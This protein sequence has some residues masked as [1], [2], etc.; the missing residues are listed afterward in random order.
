LRRQTL[1]IIRIILEKPLHLSLTGFIDEAIPQLS[2]RMTEPKETVRRGVMDF[3]QGRLHHFLVS[4]YGFGSDIVDA[5]LAVG[6]EDLV[7]AVSRT[8]ALAAFKARPDFESLAI[9]FK[10]VFNIIKEPET[11]AV[12][13]EELRSPAEQ[14]L[15]SALL[16]A[17][18][19]VQG[20]L[21]RSDYDA[22]LEAMA[23]MKGP[24]DAFFDSVLVMDKDESVRRNRLALLT[25]IHDLF[26]RVADFRKIQTA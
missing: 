24:I 3:F 1:G 16:D 13:P 2:S 11:S 21:Q 25:R 8:K 10:R 15:Y 18:A 19:V 12:K 4:Q 26:A 22:A 5:A 9:A 23:A 7:D 17:E 6:I 20:C 14:D